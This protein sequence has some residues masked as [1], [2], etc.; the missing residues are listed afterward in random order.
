MAPQRIRLRGELQVS[1]F[2]N[3]GTL[4][5]GKCCG[6]RLFLPK[7]VNK[8]AET[9]APAILIRIFVSFEGG[10]MLRTLLS[11]LTL[12][13]VASTSNAAVIFG[14]LTFNAKD[15]S[16][17]AA[18]VTQTVSATAGGR[19]FDLTFEVTISTSSGTIV[20]STANPVGGLAVASG[21][22]SDNHF[23]A[24][25]DLTFSLALTG[26][27]A[28]DTWAPLTDT[29]SFSYI[30]FVSASDASD[31]GTIATPNL[32]SW[33]NASTGPD[34]TG[35]V[36]PSGAVTFGGN[37]DS[38]AGTGGIGFTSSTSGGGVTSGAT[39]GVN[40]G[41]DIKESNGG[42]AATSFTIRNPSGATGNYLIQSVGFQVTANPEP[43]SLALGVVACG[44]CVT[45]AGRRRLRGLVKRQKS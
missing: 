39:F 32:T 10:F 9:L 18:P 36:I 6:N 3:F 30:Q 26:V 38:P 1:V 16:T 22:G 40:T 28:A 8:L 37:T 23:S 33:T 27:S 42:F 20:E 31:E 11:A 21:V 43:S 35:H 4:T 45:P 25:E 24:G 19:S 14:S 12:V 5:K 17:I 15:G 29:L 7:I 13:L 41:V 44:L 2:Q 34:F